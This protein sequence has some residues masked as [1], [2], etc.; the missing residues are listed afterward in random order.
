VTGVAVFDSTGAA[1][2]VS[3][4]GT[5]LG[6]PQWSALVVLADAGRI[7][8]LSSAALTSSPFYRAALAST[9]RDITSGSNGPCGSLCIAGP[10]YD[11]VTG[12]GSPLAGL[13]VPALQA[14]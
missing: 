4:G 5:S 2:W 7:S 13:L 12:L 3:V 14:Q 10:G 11:F 6:A 1:G 8:P 9:Y